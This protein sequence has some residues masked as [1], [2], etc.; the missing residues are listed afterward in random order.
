MPTCPPTIPKQVEVWI[1]VE[2]SLT[3]SLLTA[4]STLPLKV[5]LDTDYLCVPKDFVGLAPMSV[6]CDRISSILN[7]GVENLDCPLGR[8]GAEAEAGGCVWAAGAALKIMFLFREFVSELLQVGVPGGIVQIF[9][10]RCCVKSCRSVFLHPLEA[11]G[12]ART[13]VAIPG[14]C[15][16]L[17]CLVVRA[18]FANVNVLD[19]AAFVR[20]GWGASCFSVSHGYVCTYTGY[21][22]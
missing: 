1:L 11:I 15:L 8:A 6:L 4:N 2:Y 7:P 21:L 17:S 20:M 16:V 14:S 3:Q 10:F 19:G 12:R 13:P 18:Y 5:Y 22:S 9:G